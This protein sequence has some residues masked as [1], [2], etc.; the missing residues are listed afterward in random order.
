MLYRMQYADIRPIANNNA[1]KQQFHPNAPIDTYG[2]EQHPPNDEELNENKQL[3]AIDY[4]DDNPIVINNNNDNKQVKLSW[5]EQIQI[6]TAMSLSDN[7]QIYQDNIDIDNNQSIELRRHYFLK[8][9]RNQPQIECG[10]SLAT[11]ISVWLIFDILCVVYEMGTTMTMSVF[12]FMCNYSFCYSY[13]I[14]DYLDN[15]CGPIE[16]RIVMGIIQLISVGFWIYFMILNISTLKQLSIGLLDS[17]Y[18][19]RRFRFTWCYFI[20]HAFQYMI[21]EEPIYGLGGRG[22]M[23]IGASII[24]MAVCGYTLYRGLYWEIYLWAKYYEN[25]NK[26]TQLL[27]QSAIASCTKGCVCCK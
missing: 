8:S 18:W 10:C 24:H 4:M 19:L 22:L 2:E 27:P 17:R 6:A 12:S 21:F 25:N 9:I 26:Y 15:C 23:F 5:D 3:K 20:L 1:P 11:K 14:Y 13:E 7:E 16:Y